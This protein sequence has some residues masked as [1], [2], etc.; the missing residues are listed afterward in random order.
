MRGAV[1]DHG[2]GLEGGGVLFVLG[3]DFERGFHEALFDEVG[4]HG[5]EL[6]VDVDA[7]C[8]ADFPGHGAQGAFAGGCE[9][10][11]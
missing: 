10:G 4:G 8:A 9:E 11:V 3:L 1:S 5:E 2:F 7:L 6:P